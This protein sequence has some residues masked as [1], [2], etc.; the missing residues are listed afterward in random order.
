MASEPTYKDFDLAL[1]VHPLTRD[2]A[3]F[4]DESAIK[5]ALRNLVRLAPYDKPFNPE[6]SSPLYGLL[7]E[8]VDSVSS[9][10]IELKLE[11]LISQFERRIRNVKIEAIP[12]PDDNKYEV[13]I[14][15][16]VTKTNEREQ[17]Q[18]FLPVERL[19]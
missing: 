2:I 13:N 18:L 6:I 15:F 5:N 3:T 14:S 4:S 11:I 8:P 17:L 12:M 19:R 16:I 1:K 7:F 9:S 10:I